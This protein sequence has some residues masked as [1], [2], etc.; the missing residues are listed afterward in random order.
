MRPRAVLRAVKKKTFSLSFIVTLTVLVCAGVGTDAFAVCSFNVAASSLAFGA[1]D[2]ALGTNVT[3]NTV[4][5]YRCVGG[6]PPRPFT[7][8]DD[9]GLYE[10]GPNLNRM[11]HTVTP[12]EFIPYT[13]SYVPAA[14]ASP[15]GWWPLTMTGTVQGVNY[16]NAAEGSYSDSVTLTILP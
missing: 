1:L 6:P 16:Q 13:F 8:T 4:I 9:D 5:Q 11:R 2:P 3:V 10:T 15:N 7:V 14:G 12:T